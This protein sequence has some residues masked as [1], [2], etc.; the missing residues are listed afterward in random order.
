MKHWVGDHC[1]RVE[2]RPHAG[3]NSYCHR[4][5]VPTVGSVKDDTLQL[6]GAS[7]MAQ[8]RGAAIEVGVTVEC[9][10]SSCVADQWRRGRIGASI[11][12]VRFARASVHALVKRADETHSGN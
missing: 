7:R 4:S 6:V 2:L 8:G 3:E 9:Y 12:V 1:A 5:D 10:H 11:A